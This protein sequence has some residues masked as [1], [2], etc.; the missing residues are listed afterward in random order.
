M[1]STKTILTHTLVKGAVLIAAGGAFRFRSDAEGTPVAETFS[2]LRYQS[3]VV[4]YR[5]ME[6]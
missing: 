1:T 5:L 4:N 3:F 6:D 2:T